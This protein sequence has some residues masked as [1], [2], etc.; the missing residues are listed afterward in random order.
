MAAQHE[1]QINMRHMESAVV[2]TQMYIGGV[3]FA[4]MIQK[5]VPMGAALI[6]APALSSLIMQRS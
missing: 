4:I 6:A 3:S 2:L 5:L 1:G